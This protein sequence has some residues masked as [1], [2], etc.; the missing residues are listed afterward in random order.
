MRHSGKITQT[1]TSKKKLIIFVLIGLSLIGWKTTETKWIIEKQQGYSIY[2]APIDKKNIGEYEKLVDNGLSEVLNFFN[3]PLNK[4]FDLVIHPN[5][6]S[7]DSTWQKDWNM[8]DFR[9]EC[10][11]VASGTAFKMDLLSPVLWES[12]SCEHKYIETKKTQQL[13]THELVHVYHGQL[14]VSPDFSNTEGIDWFVEGMATYASGQCDSTR[15]SAIKEAI[16]GNKIPLRLDDFW[17]GNLKYGLSGSMV[18]YIDKKY[19]REILRKLLPL[20]RK[21]DILTVLDI[22]ESELLSEW[23]EFL[24]KS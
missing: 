10:W 8:P 24:Q 3:S 9:S 15:I 21:T 17:T 2:Y 22:T 4:N 20:N 16:S 6:Q 23:K 19:G 7:L 14:N 13:I 11:M 12:E 1:M 5:R 18:M